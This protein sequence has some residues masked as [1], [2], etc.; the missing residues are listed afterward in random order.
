MAR[1]PSPVVGH[2]NDTAQEAT[3]MVPAVNAKL[4]LTCARATARARVTMIISRFG[5]TQSTC[6]TA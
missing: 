6:L 5:A 1:E 2:A 4:L 3:A